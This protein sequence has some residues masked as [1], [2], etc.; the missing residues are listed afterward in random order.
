MGGALEGA[1]ARPGSHA[2]GATEQAAGRAGAGLRSA[3][4]S[5]AQSGRLRVG[6]RGGDGREALPAHADVVA[7]FGLFGTEGSCRPQVCAPAG[8][9]GQCARADTGRVRARMSGLAMLVCG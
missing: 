6:L 2:A 4:A 1:G 5:P 3:G 7:E 8:H 9:P